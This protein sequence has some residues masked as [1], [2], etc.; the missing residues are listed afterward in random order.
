M[1]KIIAVLCNYELLPERVGGMDYFFW[2]FDKKCKENNIQVDWFFP[3]QAVHGSYPDLNIHSSNIEN[4]EKNFLTFLKQN[5][6][7]YSHIITHFL[8]LCT[9][10]FAAVKQLSKAEIIAV[11]HNPRP[12][13][14]YPFLK[15]I[16][17]KIKGILYSKYIDTFVGVSDYTANELVKDFGFPIKNKIQ[18]IHNGILL[19]AIQERKTRKEIYPS[20]L[21]A[22]HLR[23]SKGIQDLIQAVFLLPNAIKAAIVI[24][25]YGDGPYRKTL[26]DQ[27]SRLGLEHCFHFMGSSSHLKSIYCQYDY[28]LQ[29]THMECFSLSILESLAANVPVITTNVGGNEEAIINTVNGYIF[30]AKDV[31]ALT[32]L[33]AEVYLGTKKMDFNTRIDVEKRFSLVRMVEQHFLILT[34]NAVSLQNSDRVDTNITN[35]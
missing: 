4:V 7:G 14:G 29:P 32:T 26:E 1:Y 11:D 35:Q 34:R 3:N 22:S 16:K 28:M 23:E 2:Q 30:K 24:D 19:E 25:V 31:R 27:V 8:E 12:I 5:K 18:V 9:P 15:K 6:T 17:K 33:L 13:D 10:F 20:F 21:T